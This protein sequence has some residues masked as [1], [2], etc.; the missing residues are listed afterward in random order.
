MG[1]CERR[2]GVGERGNCCESP[3]VLVLGFASDER[4]SK[5]Y[6]LTNYTLIAKSVSMTIRNPSDWSLGWIYGSFAISDWLNLTVDGFGSVNANV[7]PHPSSS[8]QLS[9][10][11]SLSPSHPLL[12]ASPNI[13]LLIGQGTTF[14]PR[15][16]GDISLN[17]HPDVA[18]SGTFDAR[19]K[20]GDMDVDVRRKMEVERVG[21]WEG[22]NKQGVGFE[23]VAEVLGGGEGRM[24]LMTEE[25]VVGV[26]IG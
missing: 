15:R 25:G 4:V 21:L 8:S 9:L 6:P 19:T 18:W 3:R 20:W 23:F 1:G 17:V 24:E 10:P 11:S 16:G 14:E 22:G 13:S 7:L 12:H 26:R 5:Q 2:A